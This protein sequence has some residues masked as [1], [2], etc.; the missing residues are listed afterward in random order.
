[1]WLKGVM[2][3]ANKV[4]Q[5][6]SLIMPRISRRI[7]QAIFNIADIPHAQLFVLHLLYVNGNQRP[8][9]LSREMQVSAPTVSGI[10]ER[11]ESA[12]YIKRSADPEDRRQVIVEI[13]AD[14]K[15]I[16]QKVRET[17]V[18]HWTDILEKISAQDAE[19]FLEI[20]RKIK[21]AV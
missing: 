18:G 13:T 12:G 20:L 10:L 5:E 19:K 1:M 16:A 9:D 21:E 3:D 8:A 17:V 11:M 4:A 14:G 7:L 2:S 6:V 15:K